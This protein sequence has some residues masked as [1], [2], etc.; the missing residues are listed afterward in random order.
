M[1]TLGPVIR[2]IGSTTHADY[3][4]T[5]TDEDGISDESLERMLIAISK[6]IHLGRREIEAERFVAI[7][8]KFAG[9]KPKELKFTLSQVGDTYPVVLTVSSENRRMAQSKPFE[10]QITT[11]GILNVLNIVF[12]SQAESVNPAVTI[13][14]DMPPLIKTWKLPPM[15]MFGLHMFG[16]AAAA[17]PSVIVPTDFACPITLQ[18][19][20]NP[21]L[22]TLDGRSYERSAITTWLS[23]NK[24]SPLNCNVMTGEQTIDSVVFPNVA[25]AD[26]IQEFLQQHPELTPEA[27]IQPSI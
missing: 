4:R 15:H 26:A 23:T 8:N 9:T 3:S 13:K 12:V 17:K 14:S 19:M 10:G 16:Q 2:G 7:V 5:L 25:L 27:D 22:L 6:T 11:Y 20:K 24:S 1:P 18:I 21:V